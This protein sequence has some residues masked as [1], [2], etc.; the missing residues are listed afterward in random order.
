MIKLLAIDPG[1]RR[2]GVALFADGRLIT[3]GIIVPGPK[4]PIEIRIADIMSALEGWVVAH[5]DICQVACEQPVPHESHAPA[6]ELQA[7]VRRIRQWATGRVKLPNGKTHDF[8]WNLYNPS[9]VVA[10][11]RPRGLFKVPGKEVIALGVKML[12]D[13]EGL[14]QNI[15][16]AIAV[17][18][19][20]L[21]KQQEA[22]V[23][24]A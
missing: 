16:D 1:T 8:Q 17:G 3:C 22:L 12:Y 9:S 10:S 18:H 19:C 13:V 2:L 23:T 4:D 15:L 21:A 5:P 14:D 20:H 11:V 7:L 24:N 6:P